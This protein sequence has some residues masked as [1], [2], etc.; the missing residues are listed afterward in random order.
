VEQAVVACHPAVEQAAVVG[1]ADDVLGQRVFGFITLADGTRDTLVSEILRNV[2]TRLASYK[3]PEG[4]EVL[5]ELPRNALSKI[6]RNLLK[7]MALDIK[8]SGRIGAAASRT[9]QPDERTTRRAAGN[10]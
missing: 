10:R 8:K 9:Q 6:D 5:D 4:L 3:V 1:V 2:A 7:T